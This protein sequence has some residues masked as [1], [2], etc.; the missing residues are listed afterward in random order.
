MI[1]IS[2]Q[3]LGKQAGLRVGDF[4]GS[5]YKHFKEKNGNSAEATKYLLQKGVIF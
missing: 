2:K 4:T 5:K 1:A 3:K